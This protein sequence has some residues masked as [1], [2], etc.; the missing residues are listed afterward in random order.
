MLRS[1]WT[2]GPWPLGLRVRSLC[3]VTGEATTVRGPRTAKRKYTKKQNTVLGQL[4]DQHCMLK[5]PAVLPSCVTFTTQN[6]SVLTL[7]VTRCVGGFPH[8]SGD[9]KCKN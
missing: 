5:K 2:R 8:T 9:L 3:S 7:E 4:Q 1:G 6:V